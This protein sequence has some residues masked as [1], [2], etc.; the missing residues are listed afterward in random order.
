M[1]AH[2]IRNI[3]RTSLLQKNQTNNFNRSLFQGLDSVELQKH[4]YELLQ[5]E[6]ANCRNRKR[7]YK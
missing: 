6:A 7:L 4:L 2:T 1:C 3:I 5:L